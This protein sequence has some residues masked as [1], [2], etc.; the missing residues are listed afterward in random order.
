M[1]SLFIHAATLLVLLPACL[2]AQ[3]QEGRHYTFVLSDL[4]P[5]QVVIC[6]WDTAN[7]D[8]KIVL[9]REMSTRHRDYH[10]K[11]MS[12]EERQSF[13]SK[14][15]SSEQS[16]LR[17]RYST[18]RPEIASNPPLR[19]NGH[20]AEEANHAIDAASHLSK[21]D[22]RILREQVQQASRAQAAKDIDG[23]T[24]AQDESTALLKLRMAQLNNS[25]HTQ[26]LIL[27]L[28]KKS[29]PNQS[30][31]SEAN[32]LIADSST[33]QEGVPDTPAREEE[34]EHFE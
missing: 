24:P 32:A 1:R 4:D 30:I 23:K 8:E 28:Q 6:P 31:P 20:N 11:R 21:E 19:P 33:G 17:H 18:K 25:V 13:R 5:Q 12:P 22:R 14:L 29:T 27:S 2:I 7:A 15:S 9:W 16:E 3:A 34:L 10:W 26:I